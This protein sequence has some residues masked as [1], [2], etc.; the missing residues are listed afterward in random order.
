MPKL[1]QLFREKLAVGHRAI[2]IASRDDLQN[3][4]ANLIL[5]KGERSN[6]VS[7]RVPENQKRE[8]DE[9]AP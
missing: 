4:Q 2:N 3:F 6:L 9:L 5:V 7:R 1:E 8:Q